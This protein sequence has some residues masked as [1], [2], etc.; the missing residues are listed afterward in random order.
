MSVATE[1]TWQKFRAQRHHRRWGREH[2]HRIR[3][4]DSM[5]CCHTKSGRTWLRVMLSHLYHLRY[6]IPATEVLKFDNLN[7]LE[8][9]IPR[10]CF[11]HRIEWPSFARGGGTVRIPADKKVLFLVRDPRDVAVSFHFHVVHRASERELY[12]KGIPE[13]ARALP[14]YDFMVHPELGVP[15]VIGFMN[16]WHAAFPEFAHH[17]LVRYED[18]RTRTEELLAE[19]VA[20]L[21]R[22]FEA[23]LI[24][25]ATSFGSFENLSRK[26]SENF[27]SDER[28]QA[29]SPENP[30]TFK[31]RR[32]VIGGYRDYFDEEQV[33]T[34]DGLVRDTLVPEY[35]Y[36]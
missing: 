19:V 33:R 34:L 12:R 25:K 18:L 29:R 14:L 9:A 27:F 17:K 30:E 10:I 11:T 22:D 28:L 8:P 13:D 7:A 32:G 20:F 4:A 36:A 15:R 1:S 21:D 23:E 5:V 2:V 16:E 6:D 24:R 3:S 26:E 35:G 31:V